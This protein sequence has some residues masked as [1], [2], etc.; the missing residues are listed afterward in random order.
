MTSPTA[1]REEVLVCHS[2]HLALR[3][4]LQSSTVPPVENQPRN[5]VNCFHFSQAL[6]LAKLLTMRPGL[7]SLSTLTPHFPY[8][9]RH[10]NPPFLTLFG[11]EHAS[12]SSVTAHSTSLS[13]TP[14]SFV[15]E[16]IRDCYL[17]WHVSHCAV[18]RPIPQASWTQRGT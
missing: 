1:G 8:N 7:L 6:R 10:L 16:L 4:H 9:V 17:R 13:E 14:I 12:D 3:R 15:M 2:L 18:K 5:E 11:C